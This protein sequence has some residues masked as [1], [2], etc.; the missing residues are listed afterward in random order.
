MP[1][2]E[3]FNASN[4]THRVHLAKTNRQGEC[5]LEALRNGSFIEW[6]THRGARDRFPKP[7]II[8]FAR[9]EGNR[10]LFGG[11]Y[12]IIGRNGLYDVRELVEFNDDI[13]NLQIEF[14][15]NPYSTAFTPE[16][17]NENCT[18]IF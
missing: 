4:E 3:Y 7:Y 16:Y 14:N 11:I 18:L 15:G 10:F 5:P 6:Q 1:F 8:A 12:Q 2:Q 17:V 13:E 9:I